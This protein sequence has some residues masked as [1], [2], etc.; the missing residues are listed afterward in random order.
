MPGLSGHAFSGEYVDQRAAWSQGVSP[1]WL[2]SSAAIEASA[3]DT[4]VL[5]PG[6]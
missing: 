6:N 2:W 1:T 3:E 4:L 5:V